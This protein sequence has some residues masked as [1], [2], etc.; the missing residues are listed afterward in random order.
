MFLRQKDLDWNRFL[1]NPLQ[2]QI[3]RIFLVD[4]AKVGEAKQP[5][6]VEYPPDLTARANVLFVYSSI[7][8]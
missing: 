1:G 6:I 8:E 4:H 3:R 5:I 7:I 2:K